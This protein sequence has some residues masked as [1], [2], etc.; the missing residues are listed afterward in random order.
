MIQKSWGAIA[1]CQMQTIFV[2]SNADGGPPGVSGVF[3]DQRIHAQSN[4]GTLMNFFCQMSYLS[5]LKRYH[6][7]FKWLH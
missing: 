3:K 5:I 6:W 4:F 1:Q 7:Y 2:S